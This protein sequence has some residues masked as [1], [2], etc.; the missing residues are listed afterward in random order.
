MLATK[1]M[2]SAKQSRSHT[3]WHDVPRTNRIKA[4]F[5]NFVSKEGCRTGAAMPTT[6]PPSLNDNKIGC[7]FTLGGNVEGL[8]RFLNCARAAACCPVRRLATH[9]EVEHESWKGKHTEALHN[10][11]GNALRN[12]NVP[13]A[14]VPAD[15][16]RARA[17]AMYRASPPQRVLRG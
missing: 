4:A 16:N 1:V 17:R 3:L 7:I 14:P 6:T 10:T 5:C 2:D 12:A 8:P 15:R 13:Y 11:S 9:R